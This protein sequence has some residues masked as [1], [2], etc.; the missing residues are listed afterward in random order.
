MLKSINLSNEK[1]EKIT[2]RKFSEGNES[3][4]YILNI[5][6]KKKIVK[7]FKKAKNFLINL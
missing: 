3:N 7:I 1:L 2:K 4:T 5:D 6:E